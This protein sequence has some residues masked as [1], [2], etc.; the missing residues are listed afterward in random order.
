MLGAIR[1]RGRPRPRNLFL[2]FVVAITA[3]RV[4]HLGVCHGVKFNVDQFA[5][6]HTYETY[7]QSDVITTSFALPKLEAN[8]RR[9]ENLGVLGCCS[10]TTK[11]D[12]LLLNPAVE[13]V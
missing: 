8:I 7:L 12:T 5:I 13:P 1:K 4:V 3:Q 9:R 2:W 10:D 11:P 6:Q